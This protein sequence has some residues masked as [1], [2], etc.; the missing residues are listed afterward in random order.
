MEVISEELKK[1]TLKEVRTLF[2]KLL[3]KEWGELEYLSGSPTKLRNLSA[4]EVLAIKTIITAGKKA[5]I[6]RIEFML[7][8]AGVQMWE[9]ETTRDDVLDDILDNIEPSN[10][11]QMMRDLK[12]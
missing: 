9:D 1:L 2:S 4:I 10:V 12:K 6:K 3:R 11:V 8:R 5:D 7:Q